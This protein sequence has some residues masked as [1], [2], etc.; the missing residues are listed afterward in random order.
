VQPT[1]ATWFVGDASAEA[2]YFPQVGARSDNARAQAVYWRCIVGFFASSLAVNPAVRHAFYTN[3][4]IPVIDGVDIGA[5]LRAWGVVIHQVPVGHRLSACA[6]GSWGN[7]FYVFDVI[8]AHLAQPDPGAL[9][10]LDSDCLWLR[11]AD[12]LFDAVGRHGALSYWFNAGEYPPLAS[13][14]G[15]TRE[16]LARFLKRLGGPDLPRVEYSGGEILA[17]SATMLARIDVRL[18]QVWDEVL[19]QGADAP[20]EEAHLLS[21]IY[22]FEGIEL[23]TAN[24]L[25][26]RMWTTFRHNDLQSADR[27]L[28]V[29]HLPAEKRTG[30]ADLFRQ[31]ANQGDRHP[32]DPALAAIL[33]PRS[34]S[35]LMGFPR[36][37]PRKLVRDLAMKLAEKLS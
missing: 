30:F 2:T 17:A 9:V 29:W 36:R 1:I 33:N 22:A 12:A 5:R 27:E 16:G 8:A 11:P 13:I 18:R 28:T 25:I 21:V 31:L 32:A 23:G 6:V 15:Q 34:Y 24:G 3:G 4:A 10:L 14:N 35:R 26:R 19:A 7:Q 37:S 20:R